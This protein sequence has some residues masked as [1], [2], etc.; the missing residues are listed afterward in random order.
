[1]P[2]S[3]AELG[4]GSQGRVFL[5]FRVTYRIVEVA[6]QALVHLAC[7]GRCQPGRVVAERLAVQALAHGLLAV[8]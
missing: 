1:M 5:V 8:R 4:E 2:G 3:Y 7:D 6:V